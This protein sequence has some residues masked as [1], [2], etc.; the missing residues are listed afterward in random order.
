MVATTHLKP[1]KPVVIVFVMVAVKG[2]NIVIFRN[3]KYQRELAPFQESTLCEG[4]AFE[5]SSTLCI[6]A[7]FA[8]P[9]TPEGKEAAS[10]LGNHKH[11]E[12]YIFVPVEDV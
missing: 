7:A 1:V 10:C 8:Q 6:K 4:C 11:P 3:K 9:N 12:D 5:N 2:R